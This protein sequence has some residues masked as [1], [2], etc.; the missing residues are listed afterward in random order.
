MSCD[1]FEQSYG[2]DVDMD[3]KGLGKKIQKYFNTSY[4]PQVLMSQW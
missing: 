1:Y 3:D 2:H 4:F